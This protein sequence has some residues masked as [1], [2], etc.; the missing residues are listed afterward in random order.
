MVGSPDEVIPRVAHFYWG[1]DDLPF[2]RFLTLWSFA[3]LNPDWTLVLHEPETFTDLE[4]TWE[5]P[6]HRGTG[7]S[8]RNY[9]PFLSAIHNLS[10]VRHSDRRFPEGLS[11][12]HRSDLL[13]W[14]LLATEGG[15]WSDMDIAWGKPLEQVPDVATSRAFVCFWPQAGAWSHSIGFLGS[16]PGA[17]PYAEAWALAREHVTALAGRHYQT[18]GSQLMMR[19]CPIDRPLPEGTT[20]LSRHVVYPYTWVSIR[21]WIA[22]AKQVSFRPETVGVHWYAG[23]PVAT[24]YVRERVHE[25]FADSDRPSGLFAFVRHLLGRFPL[26]TSPALLSSSESG[27]LDQ[28]PAPLSSPREDGR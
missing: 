22:S 14:E 5:T 9:R 16:E 2:L 28:S 17:H 3:N 11:H 1:Q 20:N 26:P 18:L 24:H 25:D 21:E 15:V 4:R 6:E 10:V 7:R 27:I 13:R 8:V 12:V 23:D 19:V